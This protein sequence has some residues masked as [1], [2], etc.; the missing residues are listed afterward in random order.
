MRCSTGMIPDRLDRDDSRQ[1]LGRDG[2]FTR[3]AEPL[4]WRSEP[5]EQ[6][7]AVDKSDVEVAEAHDVISGLELGNADEL[8]DER[9]ADEDEL[10]FPLDLASAADAARVMIGVVPGVLLAVRQ[11]SGRGVIGIDRRPLAKRL[12]RAL[13]VIM[14]A[15]AVEAGLL[16]AA[17]VNGS[18]RRWSRVR[19]QPLKSTLHSW[20]GAVTGVHGRRWSSGRRRRF[21]GKI[22]PARLR[23]V[24]IV[25]AAGQ[26]I[27]DAWRSSSASSLRGP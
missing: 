1:M 11:G 15:E 22:R 3:V 14:P 12:V 21:T 19:N 24:P 26:S 7:V 4:T 20:F 18:I 10:A 6:A 5:G 25:E 13:V 17:I 23:M 8:V 9:F 16:L 2:P 27:C